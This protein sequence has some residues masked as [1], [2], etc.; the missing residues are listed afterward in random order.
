MGG[1]VGDGPPRSDDQSFGPLGRPLAGGGQ[2]GGGID[3][4]AIPQRRSKFPMGVMLGR[5]SAN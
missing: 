1:A 4:Q 3:G 5:V 2:I